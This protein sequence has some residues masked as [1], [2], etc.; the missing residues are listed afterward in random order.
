[1]SGS[2]HTHTHTHASTGCILCAC[3]CGCM[4]VWVCAWVCSV[5][6]C[7]CSRKHASTH[8]R[9]HAH[10]RALKLNYLFLHQRNY[11]LF[12]HARYQHNTSWYIASSPTGYIRMYNPLLCS[13]SACNI[14]SGNRTGDK[15][16][17]GVNWVQVWLPNQCQY[18]GRYLYSVHGSHLV[19]ISPPTYLLQAPSGK[20]P[21]ALNNSLK[22]PPSILQQVI[23]GLWVTIWDRFDYTCRI[24]NR[25]CGLWPSLAPSLL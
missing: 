16:T 12:K 19:S 13:L 15:A 1:M 11:K 14:Q 17:I 20:T 24:Y 5:H 22:Q 2:M 6:V 18:S 4:C 25:L 9:T 10:H 3:I 7:V 8:A 23:F 21:W